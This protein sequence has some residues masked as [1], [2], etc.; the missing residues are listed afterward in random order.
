MIKISKLADYSTAVMA[1]MAKNYLQIYNAREIAGHT[2]IAVPTVSKILKCLAQAGL[3][4]SQR[5]I[6][7][8]YRLVKPAEQISIAEIIMAIDGDFA[9]TQCSHT[10]S[11]CFL[12]TNCATRANWRVI[13]QAIYQALAGISLAAMKMPLTLPLFSGPAPKF[14]SPGNLEEGL[15]S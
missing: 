7:G 6:K 11:T 14:P 13:N 10:S 1:H 5:G 9:L 12:E 8:G 15:G 2:H 4:T 3:L